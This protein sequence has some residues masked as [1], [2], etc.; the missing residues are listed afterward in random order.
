MK[1]HLNKYNL[2]K[3]LFLSF[4]MSFFV[5]SCH[6]VTVSKYR[7][8]NSHSLVISKDFKITS[9]Q[10]VFLNYGFYRAHSF[11]SG[12]RI[13]YK[14]IIIYID[15]VAIDLPIKAD[16]IFITHPHVDHFSLNDIDKI[17]KESTVIIGPQQLEKKLKNYRF[18]SISP[19]K[20]IDFRKFTCQTIPAYNY[21]HKF[22][23]IALHKEK[24]NYLGYVL[25]FDDIKIY[26]A[27][28]TD[29]IEEIKQL[30]HITV[31]LIPIGEKRTAM[32]PIQAAKIVNQIKPKFVVPIHY[33]LNKGSEQ[34]F[35]DCL[36]S[37]ITVKLLH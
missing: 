17:Y 32:N 25:T 29:D 33:K 11:Q 24:K 23:D 18:Q 27:G 7:T 35:K 19:N 4:L 31:A 30:K 13:N 10:A 2:L 26:H 36:N 5:L 9:L 20:K 21:K 14:D 8:D 1:A 34:L 16:Y 15:P 3:F 22:F 12:F 37:E 6:P 28:D